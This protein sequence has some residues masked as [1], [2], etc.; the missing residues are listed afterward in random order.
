M[1][2]EIY[3][4]TQN[5][6]KTEFEIYTHLTEVCGAYGKYLFKRKQPDRALDFLPKMFSWA[7]ALLKKVKGSTAN[8]EDIIISKFPTVC[9][10]C[11]NSPCDCYNRDKPK[12][13]DDRIRDLYYRKALSQ[14]RGL[15]D[16]Q[17][18]FRQIYEKSWGA[19][20][21]ETASDAAYLHLNKLYTRLIEELSE[22]AEAMRLHH[23]YPSNFNNELADYFAWWFA[24]SSSIHKVMHG[25]ARP[26]LAE[27]LLWKAYPGCC[28]ECML[29]HC[30]CR[31][32]P[33]RELLSK[34]ALRDL[35]LIDGL[36]QANNK[37]SFDDDLSA[38]KSK[39]MPTA[40]PI[41]CVRIDLDDFK[42][43]NKISHDVGDDALKYFVTLFRQKIRPR[44]RLYRLGGDEFGLLC[45][46][47][48][49]LE[50]RGMVERVANIFREKPVKGHK[51]GVPYSLF[52]SLSVGISQCKEPNDI[53]AAFTRADSQAIR[54]KSE[55][56]NRISISDGP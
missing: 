55:G 37:R 47:L 34:P 8:L 56:K 28:P 32:G 26:I 25:D 35:T 6:A 48:S 27:E 29:V 33:V 36:T 5:Y 20:E 39:R 31:P 40:Y 51:D 17:L 38:I 12:L 24:L 44:D 16:F 54:S 49:I 43:F 9:P 53:D 4:Q 15:N 14:Q 7:V 50:T 19:Q 52:I 2:H 11:C 10:Y 41:S 1:L 30:D 3:G 23:L 18:M 13:D 46:D 22:L 21:Q 42:E 45:P